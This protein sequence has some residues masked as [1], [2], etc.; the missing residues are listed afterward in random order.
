MSDTFDM[1]AN[2]LNAIRSLDD[3]MEDTGGLPQSNRRLRGIIP[4]SLR[5]QT[6]L[7]RP[8]ES[9]KVGRRRTSPP[10]LE[11]EQQGRSPLFSFEMPQEEE[12]KASTFPGTKSLTRSLG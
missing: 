7:N 6:I 1:G 10:K 12:K 2:P 8:K 9:K 4:R 5:H 3:W 11:R